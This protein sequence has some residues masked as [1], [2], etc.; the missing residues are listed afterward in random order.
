MNEP[1]Q[2]QSLETFLADLAS[3][4]PAPGG[5]SATA[6]NGAMAAALL[7][8]VA[9]VMQKRDNEPAI[10][11]ELAAVHQQSETIRA[12]LQD[13]IAADIA[14]FHKL[15][16]AYKLPRVT[17]ADAATRRAAIQNLTRDATEVPLQI[18]HATARLLPI[19][20]VLARRTTRLLV[21][22]VG[23]AAAMIRATVEGALLSVEVN[24][25]SLEDQQFV[26]AT[27]ARAADLSVGLAEETGGII[28]IVQQ[29]I[30]R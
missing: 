8:M 28:E 6:L 20:T 26:R 10:T 3:H 23:V 16:A 2:Q 9:A 11:S 22:D 30:A 27:R 25:T 4:S 12:E 7:S 14:V 24:L 18:A 17:D 15:A 5:G 29:R 13:L 21:S 19:C 1:V